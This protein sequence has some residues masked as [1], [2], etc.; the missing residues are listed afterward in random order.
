[1]SLSTR[2]SQQY[3]FERAW[4]GVDYPLGQYAALSQAWVFSQARLIQIRSLLAAAPLPD[5]I[6]CI[7][8][9]G[10]LARMEATAAS[11]CDLVVVLNAGI[12]DQSPGAKLAFQKIWDALTPLNLDRPETDGIYAGPVSSEKLLSRDTV[13]QVSE[14]PRAFGFR[15]TFL[16]E[17]QPVYGDSAFQSI[18]AGIVDRYAHQYVELD[19]SKQWTYLLNDLVR[20]FKSLCQ[21]YLFAE[22][23]DDRLW[24]LRNLKARHSRLLM[25]IGLL[26]LLGESS[27]VTRD[28]RGWLISRL[29]WTPLERIAA[30][31][32]V[33]HEPGFEIIASAMNRFVE[34]MST[35]GFRDRLA[36]T[37]QQAE[38]L[39]R[40]SNPD[41][42][43]L[44]QGGDAVLREVLRFAL[45]RQGDWAER[46]FE[47]WLF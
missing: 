18:A 43:L 10:S 4:L 1:M 5:E 15:I 32:A 31:Y 27:Q 6:L 26:F 19:E 11:D 40:E 39:R 17:L 3:A 25:Y 33:R 44:K 23:Y 34:A 37:E 28:K 20:Y 42:Q 24:R 46:F 47:Y 36:A 41:F 30:C 8:V 35:P 45:A 2:L 9:A 16:L 12:D 14:D 22:L 7:G 21:T 38:L 13:G 29:S